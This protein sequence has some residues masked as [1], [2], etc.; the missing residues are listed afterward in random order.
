MQQT[1]NNGKKIVSKGDNDDVQISRSE[2]VIIGIFL[3]V[4][5]IAG[6]AYI[7]LYRGY[8]PGDAIS[9]LVNAWLVSHGTV[10][11]LSSIGFV[12]PPIPTLLLIPLA[13][14]PSLFQNRMAIVVVSAL[15]MVIACLVIGQIAN[16]CRISTGWRRVIVL[17]FAFNPLV[18]V[19]A[20]N[21]M[22]E[23]ILMAAT[24]IAVYWLIRFWQTGR[25]THMIFSA[26]FFGILPLIR[27]EFALITAWSGLLILLLS[28]EKRHQFTREK[29]GQ[30]LEGTL[31]AY[32]SLVIY[33][34]FLWGIASWFIMGNPLY[35]LVNNRSTGNLAEFQLTGFGVITTPLNS[36]RII[37]DAW[38]WTFPIELIASTVLILFG[39]RKKSNFLVGFGLMPL[40]IPALQFFLLVQRANVP[41]LRYF[42]MVVPFGFL[43]AMVFLYVFPESI[44]RVRW[45]RI[46]VTIIILALLLFSNVM[47]ALQLNSYPYETFGK[48][49]WQALIGKE[50]VREEKVDQAYN[51]GKLLVKTVPA[52]SKILVD[53]F[54]AGYAVL[55]GA[56]THDIFMDF[57]D[58]NY[59]VALLHPQAYVDF[60]LIP[61]PYGDNN[62]NAINLAQPTLYGKGSSWVE[63]VNILADTSDKWKLYRIIK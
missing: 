36:L 35:F 40:I 21:G 4:C 47:S 61:E 23:A 25:N 49:T 42:V 51:L 27:Y 30:F 26:A 6:G 53:T 28:W 57:T 44:K 22:G 56:N 14:I 54:G 3:F 15:S 50:E 11:K 17:L 52:G 58:P 31:L 60:I 2:N 46:S 19:F 20:I 9:R 12:W 33:P 18:I 34:L 43:V 10:S 55:L 41:L 29:F 24:L 48:L 38:F 7:D 5:Y 13:Q 45:G 63:L 1:L 59:D 32:S 37:F 39:W 62:L 16:I 8:L